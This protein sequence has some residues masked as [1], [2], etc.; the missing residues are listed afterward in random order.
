MIDRER[1]EAGDPQHF[2][3]IVRTYAPL[4]LAITRSFATDLD[5]A[6]DLFQ[7]VWQKTY[8]KRASFS[9]HGSFEAWLHRLATNLCRSDHRSRKHRRAAL[10]RLM[11]AADSESWTQQP[12]SPLAR[13][14]RR[15]L[16]ERLHR[17]LANLSEREHEALLLRV[18]E[19]RSPDEVAA[20]MGIR[21]ATVRSL[22]RHAV[23][24]LKELMEDPGDDLSR[25]ESTD[26]PS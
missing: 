4:V 7:Q 17:A 14:E 22:I 5:H 15:E 3:E 20:A 16:H 10:E 8:E 2:E 21:K 23:K 6:E 1:L 11:G 13:L 12:M 24:R 19:G 9:G 25:R 18:F 26:R